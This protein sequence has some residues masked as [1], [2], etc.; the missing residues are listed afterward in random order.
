[1]SLTGKWVEFIYNTATGDMEHKII[2]APIGAFLFLTFVCIF[3][4]ASVKVDQWLGLPLIFNWSLNWL[5]SVPIILAGLFLM[6]YAIFHFVKVKGTPVP[7]FPPPVLVC[8]GPY[9][10]SR[11]P[12]LTGVFIQLFGLGIFLNSISLCFVFTPLFILANFWELKN[13]EEPEL[14]KRLGQE[15]IEYKEKTPMFFPSFKNNNYIEQ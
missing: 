2:Y 8:S 15:Y 3:L 5:I 9:K 13:V 4:I 6:L 11:N 10:Y 7:L 1:M 14:E 12:M